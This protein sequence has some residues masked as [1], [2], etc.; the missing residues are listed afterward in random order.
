MI[1]ICVVC[2]QELAATSEQHQADLE[3]LKQR[4]NEEKQIIFEMN[5]CIHLSLHLC[6]FSEHRFD[7]LLNYVFV[8]VS[9]C[10]RIKTRLLL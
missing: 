3:S 9:F 6:F 4:F 7:N 8:F 5:V 1:Y 10:Y 2:I